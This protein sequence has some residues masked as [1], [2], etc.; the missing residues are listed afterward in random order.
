MMSRLQAENLTI[1]VP[2]K[3]CNKDCKYC[4]SK[5]TGYMKSNTSLMKR[6]FQKVKTLARTYNVSNIMVTGKGEPTLNM[7]FVMEV[8]REFREYPLELQTNGLIFLEEPELIDRLTF[9]YNVIALSIEDRPNYFKLMTPVIQKL[10]EAGLIVRLCVNVVEK[11]KPLSV[12]YI[13]GYAIDNV[14]QLLF[15]HITATEV[16]V[17]SEVRD[18]IENN[19][20]KRLFDTKIAKLNE[21]LKTDGK[22]LRESVDGMKIYYYKGMSVSVSEY[23]IQESN[24]GEDLRSLV[25][26]EDGHLYFSWSSKAAIIF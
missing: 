15:R 4:V 14:H 9:N 8:G 21:Y 23:C 26:Q 16:P 6:N 1:S 20:C 19:G 12:D 10:K 2:Y 11:H 25:Y 13:L 5:M 18:W 17:D 3:G 22:L 24:N 7:D